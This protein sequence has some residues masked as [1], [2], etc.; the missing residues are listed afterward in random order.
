MS[1][2]LRGQGKIFLEGLHRL[3]HSGLAARIFVAGRRDDDSNPATWLIAAPRRAPD[4]SRAS[5]GN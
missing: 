1:V 5:L 3:S 2:V 4:P